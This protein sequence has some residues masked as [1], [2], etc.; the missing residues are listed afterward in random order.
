LKG[1]SQTAKAGR[2]AYATVVDVPSAERRARS[3]YQQDTTDERG[4]FNLRGLNSGK[5]TVMAF[6]EL[7]EDTHQTEFLEAYES[8]GKQVQLAR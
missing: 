4:H 5:Y 3:V 1:Q 2:V 7:E 8:S 6:D